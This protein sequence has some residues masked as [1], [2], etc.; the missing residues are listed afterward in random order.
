MPD[1]HWGYGFPIGG[2]AATD[3]DAGGVV[4]PGGV[5]FDISCGVRLLVSP[6]QH[7]DE[8]RPRLPGLMDELD[9]RIPRGAGPGGVW[10]LAGGLDELDDVLRGRRPLRGGTRPRRAPAT[11]RTARTRARSTTPTPPRSAG[12]PSSAGWARS[13]ASARA[14]TSSR[15]RSSTPSTT[16]RSPGAFGLRPGQVCVMIHCGS[17]GLGHQICTDHVRTMLTAMPRYHITVP[18]PQLACAPVNSPEGRA[19]LGAMAAAANYGRA[20]R[21]LLTEATRRAFARP[22][23]PASSTCSTTSPTTSPRSRPTRRRRRH[24][25]VRPPQGRHPRARPRVTPTCPPTSP[26]HGQP[27]LVPGSMGTASYV[28][29]GVAGGRAP[30][31]PPVTGPAG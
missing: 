20:N 13:A 21:Q 30:S 16:R 11:S 8:L 22:P 7:R 12:A 2:V 31:I 23:G 1:V 10:R 25:A 6:G 29:A 5:G 18:D 9:R 17:R 28:L 27:V 14:T 19:Y 3:I 15:S 24:A 4:S 26:Q